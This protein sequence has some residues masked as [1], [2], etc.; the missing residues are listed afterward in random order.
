MIHVESTR[1]SHV[2]TCT[3]CPWWSENAD[4][5]RDGAAVGARHEERAHRNFTQFTATENPA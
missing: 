1:Y 4:S 2:V 5:H 3:R